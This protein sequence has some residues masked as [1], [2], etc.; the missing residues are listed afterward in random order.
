MS[1]KIALSRGFFS[2]NL[3]SS[4]NKFLSVCMYFQS[5]FKDFFEASDWLNYSLLVVVL[6]NRS[7]NSAGAWLSNA[8][9]R[10]FNLA[11]QCHNFLY[12]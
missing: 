10:F 6:A 7:F 5:F 12:E 8:T 4:D 11:E 1:L 9:L 3:L 2:N